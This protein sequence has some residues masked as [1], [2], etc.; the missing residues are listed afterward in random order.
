RA[1]N[2]L[3][4][5]VEAHQHLNPIF[6]LKYD[7][8]RR[9]NDGKVMLV[10][11]ACGIPLRFGEVQLSLIALNP[12]LEVF[13]AL[14][15]N[16]YK[17][18]K[19]LG[20]RPALSISKMKAAYYPDARL[21]QLVLDQFWI[22]EECKYD[23]VAIGT[24]VS[25][26]EIDQASSGVAGHSSSRGFHQSCLRFTLGIWALSMSSSSDN[27]ACSSGPIS[28]SISGSQSLWTDCLDWWMKVEVVVAVA[29]RMI[30][31]LQELLKLWMDPL[32]EEEVGTQ[33]TF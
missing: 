23:I 20:Y 12:K 29:L 33:V 27:Y 2:E 5:L 32:V 30:R 22:N 3:V 17:S 24:G 25:D 18:S 10:L 13:Y 8:P 4:Y 28:S 6:I 16:Q 15:Y 14:S 9:I 19:S 1:I 26:D 7:S 31:K 21:E 11:E